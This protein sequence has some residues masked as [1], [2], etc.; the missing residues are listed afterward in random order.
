MPVFSMAV[1]TKYIIT[2]EWLGTFNM[3]NVGSATCYSTHGE[4]VYIRRD[5]AEAR[6]VET[7]RSAEGLFKNLQ[8]Q[9]NLR[10]S[11]VELIR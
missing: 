4:H 10:Y 2:L 3:V 7:G 11:S 6:A 5:F 9:A 8:N 1:S